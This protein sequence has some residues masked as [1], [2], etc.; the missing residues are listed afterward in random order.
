MK[1]IVLLVSVLLAGVLV[2]RYYVASPSQL[3]LTQ[4]HERAAYGMTTAALE[5]TFGPPEKIE[6]RPAVAMATWQK[7]NET[8]SFM[9]E[10]PPK[11]LQT[12]KRQPG[13]QPQS[14]R[15]FEAYYQ[16][17]LTDVTHV[18]FFIQEK[19]VRAILFGW[20]RAG[21]QTMVQRQLAPYEK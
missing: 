11:F 16:Y 19:Q 10:L 15:E 4:V 12:I 9:D 18:R 3:T 8:V 21:K 20:P 17:E 2:R 14:T 1:K 13:Y 7:Q 6:T 5:Q